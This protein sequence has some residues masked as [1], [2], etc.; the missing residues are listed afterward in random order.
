MR[1]KII[2]GLVLLFLLSAPMGM[3]FALSNSGGGEWKYYREITV[4]E[5]SGKTLTN[6]QVL[7]ELNS[8]NFDFSNAKSDG[9]DVRFVDSDGNELSY[10]IEEWSSGNAKIWIKVPTIPANGKA[11]IRMYYGNPS[12]S[13]TSSIRGTFIREIDGVVGSW[14][15]NEGEGTIVYD[16]S[17]SKNDG[18]VYGA[19]WTQGKFGKAL[20][21]DENDY[22][23]CGNDASLYIKGPIAVEAW[24]YPE[25]SGRLMF[26]QHAPNIY[27]FVIRPDNAVS[28]Q[29][30]NG[31]AVYTLSD[32]VATNTWYHV[33]GIFHGIYGDEVTLDNAKVFV[34]GISK[35]DHIKFGVP[36][37]TWS[38]GTFEKVTIGY[39][40]QSFDGIIDEFR[41]YNRALSPEEISDLYNNHG[42]TTTNYPGKVLVRKFISSEPTLT[43][44]AEYTTAKPIPTATPPTVPEGK[45]KAV[46]LYNPDKYDTSTLMTDLKS[47]GINTV[48]LSTD[49]DNIWN[50]ERFVK[51]AHENGVEVHAMIL[52]DPRCALKENHANS[53]EAVE[54][55]L[56]YNDKSLAKFDG[57]NIDIEPY[58]DLDLERVWQDYITLLEAIHEKTAGK[59][60]LSADIPKWYDEGRIKDLAP[61]LDF[62][63]I[64]AYDSGGAGWNTASEIEDAVASEMGAIRGEGSKAVIGIGVHEGFEDKGEVEKCVDELYK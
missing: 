51:S 59:T 5:N 14:N 56:D 53:L 2:A 28:F 32:E 20:R 9:F 37:R 61:N 52:E 42:Y 35:G 33:V 6:Y 10:W 13:S 17:G 45:I 43:F 54:K 21:F 26:I 25:S 7:I 15:F 16:S 23:N 46:W 38:P 31:H 64:M 4:K 12:A 27:S 19:I 39:I 57:I 18:I 63:V 48:F 60:V 49:V 8:A 44:S 41:I 30:T 58:V 1:V 55:V 47:A 3:A 62:F 36:T 34:N 11:K 22:V 50:Y 40:K 24:I 29:D